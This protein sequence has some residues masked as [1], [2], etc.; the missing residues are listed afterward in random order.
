MIPDSG[1]RG[2]PTMRRITVGAAVQ[3]FR[4]HFRA[5]RVTYATA[6]AILLAAGVLVPQPAQAQTETVLYSFKNLPDGQLPS[7]GVIRDAAGN[8]YGTT[9][10]GGAFNSGTVFKLSKH[11]RTVLYS[12]LGK[13]DGSIPQTGL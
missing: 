8:L 5:W 3:L 13:A 6:L 2:Y 1:R 12:F 7:A 11:G 4:L 10:Y 9:S